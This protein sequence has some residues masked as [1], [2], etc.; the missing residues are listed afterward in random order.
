VSPTQFSR[1]DLRRSKTALIRRNPSRFP[2]HLSRADVCFPELSERSLGNQPGNDMPKT[3]LTAARIK[4]IEAPGKYYE[5][6]L[7]L[8]LNVKKG[9]TAS[10]VLRYTFNGRERYMG[11]GS[12]TIISHSEAR[13]K[14]IRSHKLILDGKDPN[15]RQAKLR[16]VALQAVTFEKAAEAYIA[17]NTKKKWKGE[18]SPDQ[19]RQSLTTYAYPIIGDVPVSQIDKKHIRAVLDPIWDVKVTTADRVRQRIKDILDAEKVNDNRTGENPA[20]WTGHLEHVYSKRSEVRR[21]K[22]FTSMPYPEVPDFFLH[23]ID[24]DGSVARA[25]ELAI[26]NASRTNEITKALKEEFSSELGCWTIPGLKMKAEREHRVPLSRRAAA[27]VK[28]RH[29]RNRSNAPLAMPKTS[30][31]NFNPSVRLVFLGIGAFPH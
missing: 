13:T 4:E 1:D 21:V 19:W 28:K 14:A 18:K 10:W 27:L 6:N 29:H 15:D 2:A 17:K 5:G 30:R 23:L 11:L 12:L 3:R 8:Y 24:Q 22:H 16:Q 26:L 20:R 25:L 31:S 9:G 7:G